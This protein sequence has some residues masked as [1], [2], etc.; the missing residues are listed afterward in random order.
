MDPVTATAILESITQTPTHVKLLA[1]TI[2]R[3]AKTVLTTIAEM[4]ER[5]L[6]ERRTEKTI[7]RGRPREI[8]HATPLGEEYLRSIRASSMIPLAAS[9]A[10]IRRA[11][12]EGDYARR[13]TERGRDTFQ[14]FME[15]N[16]HVRTASGAR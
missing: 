2:H 1:R 7:R 8:L 10:M 3:R 13:L 6:L 12:E 14:L 15:L 11:A 5:G 16:Q 4:E 9:T